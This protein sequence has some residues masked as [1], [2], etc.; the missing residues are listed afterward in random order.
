MSFGL[1]IGGTYLGNLEQFVP[2][3]S[4]DPTHSAGS[5]L[6]QMLGLIKSYLLPY[7]Y[8]SDYFSQE[9]HYPRNFMFGRL[10]ASRSNVDSEQSLDSRIADCLHFQY[11]S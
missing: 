1:P 7:E 11:I 6:S 8:T 5:D 3:N 9:G 10:G 2:S 4:D